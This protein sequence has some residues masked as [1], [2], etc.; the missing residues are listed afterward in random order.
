MAPDILTLPR[1]VVF[2]SAVVY[3]MGVAV[4]ARRVRRRIGRSP[5]TRP[6]GLKEKLL[7]GGWV[8]VVLAWLAVPFLSLDGSRPPWAAII[9]SLV[10]PAGLALGVVM[11]GAGYAGTLWCYAAMGNAWRMG[12]DRAEKTIPVTHGPYRFVRHPIY[13]CQLLMVAAITPL[14]PSALS[15]L[16]LAVH[17]VC[18]LIKAADE[19]S[20]LRAVQSRDYQEYRARTGAWLPRLSRRKPP[21]AAQTGGGPGFAAAGN[22]PPKNDPRS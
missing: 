16:I 9:P 4:Q 11:M 2:G 18:V 6:R 20:F 19:E 1:A 17:L 21:A 22:I 13:L 15:L 12:V 14:L 7:W 5:N 10:H 3:W 8:F